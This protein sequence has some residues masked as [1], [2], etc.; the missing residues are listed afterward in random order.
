MKRL[1]VG[2]VVVAVSLVASCAGQ[3]RETYLQEKAGEFV[4]EKPLKEVWPHVKALLKEQGYSW[5]DNPRQAFIRTEFK[6]DTGSSAMST[7]FTR[8]AVE[9]FAI[10]QNRSRIRIMRNSMTSSNS[11]EM[12]DPRAATAGYANANAAGRAGGN[13]SGSRDLKMEW[14]LI[15]RAAPE[16]AAKLEA[17]AAQKFEK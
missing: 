3:T 8:Y 1:L 5:Q 2:V 11:G 6:E 7:S 13:A 14:Q 10:D 4:F 9:G 12:S 17:E 16:Q 15:Q